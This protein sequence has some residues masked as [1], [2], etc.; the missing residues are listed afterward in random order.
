[1]N[2]FQQMMNTLT[3]LKGKLESPE[4]QTYVFS[5]TN[6]LTLVNAL[7]DIAP[8]AEASLK[9]VKGLSKGDAYDEVRGVAEAVIAWKGKYEQCSICGGEGNLPDGI[10]NDGTPIAHE[11]KDCLGSGGVEKRQGV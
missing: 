8:I 9:L 1:V 5:S 11:C 4:S 7:I 3:E 2:D 6:V 10:G